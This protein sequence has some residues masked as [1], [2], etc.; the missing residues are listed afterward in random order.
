MLISNAEKADLYI[1]QILKL[2]VINV[3]C[4][5]IQELANL[6]AAKLVQND[7]S[8]SS[9]KLFL[10]WNPPLCMKTVGALSPKPL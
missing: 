7:G 8:P 1:C 10:L 3:N 6:P 2:A 4:V 5:V 9:L